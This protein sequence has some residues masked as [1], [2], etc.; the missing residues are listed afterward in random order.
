MAQFK[1]S[2]LIY[3]ATGFTGRLIAETAKA[4]G[5]EPILAGRNAEKLQAI[6]GPLGLKVRAFDINDRNACDK[7]MMGIKLLLNCA[8]PFTTTAVPL[9]QA[10]I[11]NSVHYL[12]IAGEVHAVRALQR[13]GDRAKEDEVML[14]PSVAFGCMPSEALL[15]YIKE[16]RPGT[17]RAQVAFAI[18]GSPS[19]GTVTTT[20]ECLSMPGYQRDRD[21]LINAKP[22]EQKLTI[23]FGPGGKRTCQTNPWRADL[24][25]VG[26]LGIARLE[27]FTAYPWFVLDLFKK[28]AAAQGQGLMGKI[29]KF[30]V[31]RMPEGPDAAKR[32][33]SK[34][35]FWAEGVDE[36]GRKAGGVLVGPN[37]YDLT[38]I[39]ALYAVNRVLAGQYRAG[40]TT[41]G[42]LFGADPLTQ[43][44][45]VQF[46]PM[47]S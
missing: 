17:L 43:L 4:A 28:P 1:P 19:K 10:C 21:Q 32:S 14:L 13:L 27:T 31:G 22:A 30:F 35:Y 29:V 18:D 46:I 26:A 20:F 37:A 16:Q 47:S 7:G 45:G 42:E 11:R 8:G 41:C 39:C 38:A 9:A 34:S 36:D 5:A 3:G 6:A 40:F 15:A 33:Q 23:D 24:F 2:W 44:K 12:D 25:N